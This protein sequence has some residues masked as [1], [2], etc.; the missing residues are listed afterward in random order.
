MAERSSELNEITEGG[1]D[2]A[3]RISTVGRD[4]GP[5]TPYTTTGLGA[6]PS[7]D[8]ERDDEVRDLSP[9]DNDAEYSVPTTGGAT[10]VVDASAEP[11]EIRAQIEQTRTEMSETISAIQEKLSVSNLVEQAKEEISGQVTGVYNSAKQALFGSAAERFGGFM[12]K[13][14]K[15]FNQISED[16]G[17]AV[18]DAS[19]TV[20]RTAK[21]NPIPFALIGLGVGMLLWNS[22]SKSYKTRSYNYKR[23][24]H[25]GELDYDY[26]DTELQNFAP[27]KSTTKRAYNAVSSTANQ[28]YEGVTGAASSAYEG[29]TSYAGT[30]YDQA[31]NLGAKAKD[32]AR[33]T[34][35]TY[36]NQLEQNPLIVGAVALGLG[37][38]V[39]LS[40]PSTQIEGEYLGEY[41]ENLIQK[42]Q[43][44][45]GGLLDKA[46]QVAGSV[47]DKAQE[48]AGD[49]AQTAQQEA[50]AQGFTA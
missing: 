8:T 17:P 42:A 15:N 45:A 31:G 34:S 33:W 40:L 35:E 37:A 2:T 44:A 1:R 4:A 3:D 46:Q 30:A 5:A 36:S 16:Y 49:V 39:G 43:D 10:E 26:N 20:V 22:R 38:V 19:R 48:A 7:T 41:R 29:L 9:T 23:S 27:R 11:E 14:E 21:S 25:E 18:S 12:A 6:Y 24:R 50:K 13:V 28:A 47:I 32:A